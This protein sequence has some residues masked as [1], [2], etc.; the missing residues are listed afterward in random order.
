MV[1]PRT[2]MLAIVF[3]L[4]LVGAGVRTAYAGCGTDSDCAGVGKC[5]S[6]QCGA[7]GTDSDCHGHGKCSGGRCGSC[8]TDSDCRGNGKCSSGRCGSCGTDSD[9]S[10]GKCSSSRCGACGTD[11]D[12]KGGRCSSGRCSNALGAGLDWFAPDAEADC[13]LAGPAVFRPRFD[14]PEANSCKLAP[15]PSTIRGLLRDVP[16]VIAAAWGLP[17]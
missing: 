8:G 6:G 7:C 12:C 15:T 16:R 10:V 5:S 14:A 13:G 11:S 1:H 4:G 9:C 2:V 17:R 3:V